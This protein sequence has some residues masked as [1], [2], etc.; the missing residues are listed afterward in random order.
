MREVIKQQ[1]AKGERLD[2]TWKTDTETAIVFWGSEGAEAEIC[3][4]WADV[5]WKAPFRRRL[6][7]CN[8]C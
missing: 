8:P 1:P 5:S 2:S 3:L 7:E 4:C 6:Y